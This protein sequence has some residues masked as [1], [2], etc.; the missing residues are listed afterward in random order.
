MHYF[1]L[2][3]SYPPAD[4][5]QKTIVMAAWGVEQH[6]WG[7]DTAGRFDVFKRPILKRVCSMVESLDGAALAAKA[8]LTNSLFRAGEIDRTN[9]I[10]EMKRPDL[11]WSMSA[12]FVLGTLILALLTHNQEVGTVDIHFDPK[13]LKSVH[14]EAWQNA[15]RQLVITRTKQFALERG[16]TKLKKLNIR[17][18]EP[19]AKADHRGRMRDKFSMGIWVA[20]KLCSHF[21]EIKTVKECSRISSLDMSESV[22]RTTQQFDGKA[23]D[24]S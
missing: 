20:D 9:D 24:E 21:D 22:R 17:R 11:I 1:F 5:G 15:L 2:D 10:P 6:R 14:S 3:E 23:F 4:S 8:T 19:V 16:F 13:T 18:V 7:R 12:V